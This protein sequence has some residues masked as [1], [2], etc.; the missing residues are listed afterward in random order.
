MT[1]LITWYLVAAMLEM[2]SGVDVWGGWHIMGVLMG[3]LTYCIKPIVYLAH[4]RHYRK[5]SKETI[6]QSVRDTADA[7][8]KTSKLTAT[9]AA[10]QFAMRWK[11]KAATGIGKFGI[12]KKPSETNS[13]RDDTIP[14][15]KKGKSSSGAGAKSAL[16]G[17]T[18][19]A[20]AMAQSAEAKKEAAA[21]VV[22]TK[23]P[24]Q[25]LLPIPETTGSTPGMPLSSRQSTPASR[26][27]TKSSVLLSLQGSDGALTPSSPHPPPSS[28]TSTGGYSGDDALAQLMNPHSVHS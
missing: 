19:A 17:S 2:Y 21:G 26:P 5:A 14:T 6:P 22:R 20:A 9:V 15:S 12:G 3:D 16:M 11:R 18:I 25:K 13:G 10:Q 8:S 1:A 24:A 28:A 23:S 27:A 4:N 7:K